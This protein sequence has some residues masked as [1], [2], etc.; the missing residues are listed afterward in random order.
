MLLFRISLGMRVRHDGQN[1]FPLDGSTTLFLPERFNLW[2]P[3]L[4]IMPAA[5][6]FRAQQCGLFCIGPLSDFSLP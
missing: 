1:Y 4:Y 2:T 5:F 6:A 3:C